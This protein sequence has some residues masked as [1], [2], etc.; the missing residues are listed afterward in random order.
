M[1]Y[2]KDIRVTLFVSSNTKR[3]KLVKPVKTVLYYVD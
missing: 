2:E 1:N 3:N